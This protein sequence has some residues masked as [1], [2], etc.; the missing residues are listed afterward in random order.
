[1][2]GGEGDFTPVPGCNIPT[3]PG[4]EVG[5]Y[6][7]SY[8]FDRVDPD[9]AVTFRPP[10]NSD[11]ADFMVMATDGRP[12]KPNQHDIAVMWREGNL[13]FYEKP[14]EFVVRRIARAE[15]LDA[16]QA[17]EKD[18][19]C[20]FRTAIGR[21][22]DN[23]P[24]SRSDASLRLFIADAMADPKIAA[25]H[26]A[27][28]VCPATIRTWLRERGTTDHR[29]DRDGISMTGRMPRKMRINHPLEITMYWGARATH[30]RGSIVMNYDRYSA[31]ITKINT[32]KDLNRFFFIDP[33]G[34]ANSCERP[35]V[36]KKPDKPFRAISYRRFARLCRA[37]SS[38]SS[39]S[40]KTTRAGAYQRFGGGGVSDLA[41]HLGAFAWIDDTP[42]PKVFFMDDE[43]GIPIGQATMTLM[44]EQ[45]SKVIPGWDISPGAPSSATMLKTVLHAN[46]PKDVPQD[47]LDIDPNLTWLRL[48]PG[49]IG[50]DNATSNHSQ[51]VEDALA[52]NYIG[53]RYFGSG[54]PRDK[55]HMERV[56]G[57]FLGLVFNDMEGANYDIE[58]MRR[59]KFNENEFFDPEK[60]ILISIEK[61][62]SLL[63]RAAMT[64]NITRHGGLDNRQP[65]L[66]WKQ[67]LRRRK[68]DV[69][70]DEEALALSCMDVEFDMEMTN[71]EIAKFNRRYTPGATE[72]TR[73]LE[74]FINGTRIAKG[75]IGVKSKLKRDDRKRLSF[76]V[77]GKYNREDIG[78][79]RI[80]NPYSTP[81]DWENIRMLGPSS[82]RHP[83]VVASPLPRVC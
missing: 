49:T 35:A 44:L 63:A 1:M 83:V 29:K 22:F 47:L 73:I 20:S 17:R 57:T 43:T 10:L 46:L 31:D 30:V 7:E 33:D 61:A 68:L 45:K 72:M 28:A 77:K 80:W 48:K 70:V 59:Y 24:W 11:R 82:I 37:L 14:L 16:V 18:E 60:H 41:T 51:A 13:T 53:I 81:A 23:N 8:F 65:A 64:Y 42:I 55:S 6:G 2:S 25:L 74:Q 36:Y 69:I 79:L 54:M 32:G 12:R 34:E 56:I 15:K 58:R 27:R 50:S 71:S 5:L 78:A 19:S 52:D 21:Q 40:A 26:G 76:K 75:D 3:S 39:Y 9:G 4:D 62:R 38:K 67:E 66:V